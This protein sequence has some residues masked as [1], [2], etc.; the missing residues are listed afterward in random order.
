MN[1]KKSYLIFILPGFILYFLFVVYPIFSAAQIS[2][3][4][5]NGIGEKVFVGFSNYKEL[6]SNPVLL[7]QFLNA[8]KNSLIIFVLTALIIIPLQVIYAYMIYTKTKG[9][10]ILQT[11][12][13]SPQFISTP[14]IVFIFTLM[15]DAN[16]GVVNDFLTKIGLD[17]LAKPWLGIP[18]IGI[19]IVWLMISWAGFG[20]GMMYFI[21]AMNMISTDALESAYLEGAGFWTRLRLIVVPQIKNT[22]FNL[23]LI[24]YITA[25][26]I[27]DYSYILGGVSGGVDGSVDVMSL[28][29]Y[30]IAFGDNNPL[31]GNLSEN[32]MGMGTTIAVTLFIIIFIVAV[33]QM[34]LTL[35]K[36]EQDG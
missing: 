28:F 4:K 3:F 11:V 2:L 6:F 35:R 23:I 32:S 14:V 9:S 19:Y 12:I 29:F 33:L 36:D 18:S 15:L 34:I 7:D 1:K 24:S 17:F 30:R 5:W 16:I 31:G 22:I 25:M 21:A 20:V 27:F 26:T 10:K 13:F 8:L